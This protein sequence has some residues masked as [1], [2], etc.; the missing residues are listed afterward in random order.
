MT[1]S[2]ALQSLRLATA[3]THAELERTMRIAAH[4]AGRGQYAEYVAAI[5]GWMQPVEP[6][7]WSGAWPEALE[8]SARA[9]KARW[10]EQDIVAARSDGY[11]A[12]V[13]ALSAEVPAF[14][15]L[16]HRLGWAYVIEGSLL[17]ARALLR[18]MEG[19][20]DPWPARWLQGYG[21]HNGRRWSTFLEALALNVTAPSQV[22]AASRGALEAFTSLG[23]WCRRQGAA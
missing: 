21:E 4:G 3:A 20:L 16:A 13:I 17:G 11:I 12:G 23:A 5:W 6:A 10:L 1:P 2:P 14:D 19:A 8:A 7:L 18:R 15:S 22:E 9:V